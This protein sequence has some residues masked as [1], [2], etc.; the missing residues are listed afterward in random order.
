[1]FLGV[2]I[3]PLIQSTVIEKSTIPISNGKTLYV[4]GSGEGNYTRIQDAIDNTSNG[5]TVFVYPGHYIENLIV[6]KSI[7]LI[8]AD[9]HSTI[10]NGDYKDNV[11]KLT[12][13][14]VEISSFSIIYSITGEF[15]SYGI[16]I[17][18]SNNIIK[19][20]AI[21]LN[22]FGIYID[23]YSSNNKILDNIILS[24]NYYGIMITSNYS[25]GNHTV[26]NNRIVD[27]TLG[28]MSYRSYGN[29]FYNN[30]IWMNTE[31]GIEL[32]ESEKN[33]IYDNFIHNNTLDGIY[34]LN[35]RNN[36]ISIN[37][38]ENNQDKG[39]HFLYSK[40]NTI[41]NNVI[42]NNNY[43]IFLD[44]FS[45]AN[46]II[47]NNITS[48]NRSS[49]YL[50]CSDGNTITGNTISNN[51]RGVFINQSWEN[52]IQKNNFLNNIHDS[53]FLYNLNQILTL[54]RN[55]WRQNYWN[56]PRLLPKLIFGE[57]IIGSTYTIPWI[58]IDCRPAKE[59]YDI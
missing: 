58:N 39:I 29:S 48:S 24:N 17:Y 53:S 19:D 31:Y 30:E 1:L 36:N 56:R 43:G 21:F 13:D 27:N 32:L 55:N 15:L 8:G 11:T 41:S 6:D 57:F 28:V 51:D 37:N 45:S 25:W 22:N 26:S 33:T 59:P 40:N 46:T 3:A 5:D 44:G 23:Y 47:G 18:S 16:G 52:I 7:K 38:I 49:I 34:F 10:I 20:N 12:A 50:D 14:G 42:S 54:K 4:G 2:V 9:Y 35:A